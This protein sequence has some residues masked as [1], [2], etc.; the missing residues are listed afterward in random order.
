MPSFFTC[1]LIVLTTQ[2]SS[3]PIL[4]VG[5][6]AFKLLMVDWSKVK[7]NHKGMKGASISLIDLQNYH[8]ISAGFITYL[9]R[10]I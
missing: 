4:Q 9:E 3:N 6:R 8:V 7:V 1:C 10:R 2:Y 5:H